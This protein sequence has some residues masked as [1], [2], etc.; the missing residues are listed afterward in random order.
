MNK[1][2]KIILSTGFI[3]SLMLFV[4]WS[5]V[6]PVG[7]DGTGPNRMGRGRCVSNLGQ[8]RGFGFRNCFIGQCAFSDNQGRL[9]NL[10]NYKEGLKK[11]L[12]SVEKKLKKLG[13]Y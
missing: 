13:K 2:N 5:F 9:Q 7:F 1:K 6:L 11:E 12:R 10:K 4:V 3:G 8:G